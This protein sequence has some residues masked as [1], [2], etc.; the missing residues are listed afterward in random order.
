MVKELLYIC[1]CIFTPFVLLIQWGGRGAARTVD[2][3][4]KDCRFNSR[5]AR[6]YVEMS[7]DKTLKLSLLGGWRQYLAPE[8]PPV[9]ECMRL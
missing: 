4:S 8:P 7:L 9:C 5:L 3:F 2:F 6:P 1:P